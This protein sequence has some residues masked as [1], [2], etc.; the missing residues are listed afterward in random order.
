MKYSADLQIRKW[1]ILNG[2]ILIKLP[3]RQ[4]KQTVILVSL[5]SDFGFKTPVNAS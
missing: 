1:M 3:R 2:L 4:I 5:R